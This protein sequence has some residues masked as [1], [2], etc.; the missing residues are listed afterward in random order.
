VKNVSFD[1]FYHVQQKSNGHPIV[2]MWNGMHIEADSVD[3][4]MNIYVTAAHM[5]NLM[6]WP[7]RS[8]HQ[9]RIGYQQTAGM[10]GPGGPQGRREVPNVRA[11]RGGRGGG[12]SFGTTY[13]SGRD[14]SARDIDNWR[15]PQ[16]PPANTAQAQ[17]AH[18]APQR[19]PATT[20]PARTP[21]SNQTHVPSPHVDGSFEMGAPN[22]CGQ[23]VSCIVDENNN[24]IPISPGHARPVVLKPSQPQLLSQPMESE[25]AD[26]QVYDGQR[27]GYQGGTRGGHQGGPWRGG[28]AGGLRGARSF[29]EMRNPQ[30]PPPNVLVGLGIV[31]GAPASSGM[32]GGGV[33]PHQL[34]QVASAA[35]FASAPGW[36]PFTGGMPTPQT[37]TFNTGF[38]HGS[39][40][41][42]MVP[43]TA[44]SQSSV[45]QPYEPYSAGPSSVY[46]PL[47]AYT[48]EPSQSS[49]FDLRDAATAPDFVPQAKRTD[50]KA[51]DIKPS[52]A[53]HPCRGSQNPK[54]STRSETVPL[55]MI[56]KLDHSSWRLVGIDD[57][58]ERRY[59]PINEADSDY[60]SSGAPHPPPKP[61]S[62]DDSHPEHFKSA[63][64]MAGFDARAAK[65]HALAK[66]AHRS[67]D[68]AQ[69]KYEAIQRSPTPGPR[70]LGS[71]ASLGKKMQ[72]WQQALQSSAST[73]ARLRDQ[74]SED[75]RELWTPENSDAMS[76][77]IP[78]ETS[79]PDVW[80]AGQSSVPA[81]TA[82]LPPHKQMIVFELCKERSNIETRLSDKDS[83]KPAEVFDLLTRRSEI[84][85]M[86]ERA[87]ITGR[88]TEAVIDSRRGRPI[89][90]STSSVQPVNVTQERGSDAKVL[91]SQSLQGSPPWLSASQHGS[92]RDQSPFNAS[93]DD[94]MINNVD[95]L[96]S[97][98]ANSS[99]TVPEPFSP[100][101]TKTPTEPPATARK[102]RVSSPTPS[103]KTDSQDSGS[104]G[105]VILES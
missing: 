72:K 2:N 96:V 102:V 20:A 37:A 84:K 23:L 40:I 101:E 63:N 39:Y 69:Q 98:S 49:G 90:Q 88:N 83:I 35:D 70:S 50:S 56:H 97:S 64:S 52:E 14:V 68:R 6:A 105:G 11:I 76:S 91:Q 61:L 1:F 77:D 9:P 81:G 12:S 4:V 34:R 3:D 87:T 16:A 78:G 31:P 82:Y 66:Q 33:N 95:K 29:M 17:I 24:L 93:W 10:S 21:T 51:T 67:E 46:T 27:G 100:E 54:G 89:A 53:I 86:I 8:H 42:T 19:A 79:A 57:C 94:R 99:V 30:H 43:S 15:Q 25:W 28:P 62:L 74:A 85:T 26:G 48:A 73:D 18:A 13:G 41:P 103:E 55:A 60:Q 104:G 75:N 22:R 38:P 7:R 92:V 65:A 80:L 45:Y 44:S 71:T 59:E 47:E 36:S 32:G 5:N 58:G